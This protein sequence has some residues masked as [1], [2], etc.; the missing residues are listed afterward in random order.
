[1]WATWSPRLRSCRRVWPSLTLPLA[2]AAMTAWGPQALG[3]AH[4]HVP[5]PLPGVQQDHGQNLPGLHPVDTWLRLVPE[6]GEDC[7]HVR[8]RSLQFEPSA[9][10]SGPGPVSLE[11]DTPGSPFPHG[12][13]R[14]RLGNWR[15]QQG[16][17]DTGIDSAGLS[18][19]PGESMPYRQEAA[20]RGGDDGS[21]A[22]RGKTSEG[23]AHTPMGIQAVLRPRV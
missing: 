9:H 22:P 1:M 2:K 4:P 18:P 13:G 16:L 6:A 10:L 8:T 21:G 17:K 11:L 5:S 23:N 3:H 15:P 12:P 14:A 19:S 20:G 7:G